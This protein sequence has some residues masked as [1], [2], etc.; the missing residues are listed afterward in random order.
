MWVPLE[1]VNRLQRSF[2]NVVEAM[3]LAPA[4]MHRLVQLLR[5][6]FDDCRKE[7]PILRAFVEPEP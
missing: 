5:Y 1:G 7:A 2:R 6:V 3:A 4:D